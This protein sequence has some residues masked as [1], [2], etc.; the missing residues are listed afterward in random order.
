MNDAAK[1]YELFVS[2]PPAAT[3]RPMALLS[4]PFSVNWSAVPL[5][6]MQTMS[7]W[8]AI[9][10]EG[11]RLVSLWSPVFSGPLN[12]VHVRAAVLATAAEWPAL[13][14][15]GGKLAQIWEPVFGR[16]AGAQ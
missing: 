1:V 12:F 5:A 7:E 10:A 3:V 11:G 15:T 16:P 8:P 9:Q 6:V 13:D 2:D 14:Q 4:P